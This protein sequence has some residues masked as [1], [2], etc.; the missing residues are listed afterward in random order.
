MA[1]SRIANIAREARQTMAS[2]ALTEGQAILYSQRLR[3]DM[4]QAGL[5]PFRTGDN[6]RYLDEALF[7]LECGLIERKADLS[8]RWSDSVKRA[9]QLLEWLSLP[10]LSPA[11]VPLHLLAAAAYQLAGYPAMAIGLLKRA[12][13][14]NSS[15]ALS[16][17]LRGDFPGTQAALISYWQREYVPEQK[18]IA[19]TNSDSHIGSATIRHVLMS[20]GSICTYF[21]TGDGEL[22]N[23][24]MV[25][26]ENLA[27]SLIY[28]RD[29]Y[30]HLLAKLTAASCRTYVESSIWPRI[31]QLS[32]TSTVD[33]AAALVQFG[34]AS[35]INRRA[36]VWPAQRAGIDRLVSDTSFVLCT[37]TGSGKTT[38]ATL[39]VVQS[40]FSPRASATDD[41]SVEEH[42]NIALYLVPSRALAAEVEQRLSQDL[43]GIA[44]TPLVVT[45]LYGGTDWGPTD[46]W[47]QTTGAT[48][49]I[50]TFEKADALV[51]YLGVLFMDRVKVIIVDEAHMVEQDKTRITALQEGSS[52]EFR[53]EQLCARLLRAQEAY[54][55]RM[56]ALSAVAASAGPSLARWFNG[57]E[58][59]SP[60]SST[61]RSTRQMIGRLEVSDAG[62]YT[63]HYDLMDG[64]SLEFTEG[65][66]TQSPFVPNPFAAMPGGLNLAA[67]PEVRMRAPTLW[68][69]LQLASERPDGSRPSVLISLTQ[70]VDPFASTC[71]DLLESWALEKLPNYR[72]TDETDEA[73]QRCLASAEDY[74]TKDSV[75]Y[76]LLSKGIVVHHGK[77][78]GQLSRRLKVVIDK[79]L[80]RVI[81]ATSTLS[82]GVNIPVNY[83]LL[84]GLWRATSSLTVQEFGNLAGRAGRPGVATEGSVLV[85]LP[86]TPNGYNR[87]RAAYLRL[88]E[89]VKAA[90]SPSALT[91]LPENGSS[92]LACLL[93]ELE[94][95]W[96]T[97]DGSLDSVD[98]ETWL[99]QTAIGGNST[100][101]AYDYLDTLDS[102]LLTAIEEVEELL[103]TDLDANGIEEELTRIWRRTYAFASSQQEAKLA[104]FWLARGRAIKKQYPD[105]EERRRIY[106]TSLSPRSAASMLQHAE[107]IRSKLQE[108]AG[109]AQLTAEGKLTFIQEVLSLLSNVPT[110]RIENS[111]GSGRAAVPWITLLRWWLFKG[112]LAT[113]PPSNKITK[114]F[115]FVSKNFIYRG[116]WGLGSVIGVLLD[117]GEDDQPIRALEI[118]DWPKSELPWI[119]FWLKELLL[120]GTLDP[121]AAFLLA[122]GNALNRKQAEADA[123]LYYQSIG[124]NLDND[125]LDP[126]QIRDWVLAN[127]SKSKR[128]DSATRIEAKVSLTNSAE[129]YRNAEMVVT[130]VSVGD[131]TL[132]IDSAGHRVASSETATTSLP[133]SPSGFLY[134]LFVQ[135]SLVRGE[136]YLSHR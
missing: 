116:A 112:S 134:R 108:G 127:H 136:A 59:A 5:R 96:R 45:G 46:A 79:G 100:G 125:A 15:R 17:F 7:L 34:R 91:E 22:L 69:A 54:S 123:L 30:S 99:E 93:T 103:D 98:F 124:P 109:Y 6:E 64:H 115:D 122:R 56:I 89:E 24:A 38:V 113:Q 1:K 52:R 114:W 84:P 78:P 130:P 60:V 51:R 53:V 101:I 41:T 102:F 55:F 81:I 135:E 11:E 33:A 132:W 13:H 76:R 28:S 133:S 26:L 92:P 105:S 71:A 87:Q 67:G 62:G 129:R 117:K 61:Y 14:S 39:A 88:I 37:P 43:E 27:A 86:E 32:S 82:E 74:F 8:G 70:L 50:C 16:C 94:K 31:Q 119:A 126:R 3:L 120:W 80:V 29:P 95:A 107:E 118:G 4:G 49:V 25:K 9:A 57:A 68:A 23:R 36:L 73:W 131:S 110:F 48:V 75:E 90:N 47:I 58:N 19:D 106:K 18:T 65:R 77:M 121:V 2:S 128:I 12:P 21:Q 40:L 97:L 83:V 35:F 44:A 42:G 66:R 10:Q 111:L 72:A 63:I 20:L 85:V 104:K